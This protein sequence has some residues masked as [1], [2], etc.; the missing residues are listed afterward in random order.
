M[1]SNCSRLLLIE[2]CRKYL[3]SLLYSTF[4]TL[5]L[6]VLNFSYQVADHFSNSVRS[7]CEIWMSFSDII[8][9]HTFESSTNN[10]IELFINSGTSFKY[11]KNKIGPKIDPCGTPLRTS[12]HVVVNP[13]SLTN[14]LT[15][16]K[17]FKLS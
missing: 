3:V 7:C 9:C 10:L 2:S 8:L 16:R 14:F 15:V 5:H 4:I 11:I 12:A 1:C 13:S 17:V 6:L